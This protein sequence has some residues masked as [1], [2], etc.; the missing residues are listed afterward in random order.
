MRRYVMAWCALLPSLALALGYQGAQVSHESFAD[1]G[2]VA[3][4]NP[5]TPARDLLIVLDGQAEIPHALYRL[6]NAGHLIA[7]V[8]LAQFLQRAASNKDDCLNAVTLLDVFSQH[9]QEKFRFEHYQRPILIGVDSAAPFALATLAQAPNNLFQAG[10]GLRFQADVQL[11]TPL[12]AAP[13]LNAVLNDVTLGTLSKTKST[14]KTFRIT[15]N[16]LSTAWLTIADWPELDNYLDE[17]AANNAST[18][19]SI[20]DLALVELPPQTAPDKGANTKLLDDVF[21]ILLSGDGGWANIDKDI[22]EQLNRSGVPVV[23]WNSL[24]YFW[25]EKTPEHASR[26]LARAIAHYQKTWQRP[27]VLLIGF[28]LGAD[29]LPFMISRLPDTTKI[30]IVDTIFLGLGRKVDF[31]FHVT[32]WIGGDNANARPL[33]PELAKLSGA[34]MLCI[35]GKHDEDTMC[36]DKNIGIEVVELPGDHHFDGDYDRAT[37]LIL[38]HLHRQ[39]GAMR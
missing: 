1:L 17:L 27:R 32:D 4:I 13:A 23:G 38:D 18:G 25:R 11:P 12:C 31:Q 15:T 36:G 7:H 8:P 29:V 39:H 26:D 16:N 22:G 2:T 20:N 19:D 5:V 10:V 33:L 21:V 9:L 30:A 3:I 35:Y 14:A 37:Q 24:Q 6:A 28:S 34:P